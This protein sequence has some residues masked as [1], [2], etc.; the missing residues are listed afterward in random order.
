MPFFAEVAAPFEALGDF[1]RASR[2][3]WLETNG[4]GGYAMGTVAGVNTRRYHGHL[5]AAVRPPT[6]RALF[7]AKLDETALVGGAS[8]ELATNQYPGALSPDGWTRVRS[9]R[10][11]P[12]PTWRFD[13]GGVEVEKRLFLVHGEETCVVVYHASAPIV[14]RVL[15]FVAFRDHH[16]LGMAAGIAVAGASPVEVGAPGWPSLHLHHGGRF[17]AGAEVY[18]AFEHLEEM[19]RGFDFREDLMKVGAIELDV[20]PDRPGFVVATLGSVG[21]DMRR[22]A[23]AELAEQR[24]RRSRTEDPLRARLEA[25]AEHFVVSRADGSRTI[26]AGYPWF[27][28]WGR[29]TMISLPGLL[30]ARGRLDDARS[31]IAGFLAHLDRGL[32]PNRFPDDAGPPEY[33]TADATLWLFQA[34]HA[35]A[36]SGGDAGF[37]RDVV[38]PAARRIIDWHRRGTH[39]GIVVDPAD[40]LLVAG[41]PGTQ[42]TWMDA[43]VGGR[44][45]TPRHGKPVEV[46]ALWYNALRLA[47]GWGLAAGDAGARAY[48]DEAERVAASFAAAFW[49]PRRGC[50]F[51][52]VRDGGND[53]RVRPNQVLAVALPYPLLS[54]E[55]QRAVL[56]VVERD[57]LTDVGPR[58]LARGEPG[59]VGH[60][61][62]GSGERD[63]AYH[64]GAVWPWL[65]GPYVRAYLRVEERS[66]EALARARML[67]DGLAA[68]LEESG[69]LGSLGELFDGDPPHLPGG[70]PA[71]AWSVAEVLAL[72]AGEL[73][74]G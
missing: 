65:V 56:T 43:V 1:G 32:I 54:R 6:E 53:E 46:N 34:V 70:A 60:Y 36:S 11:A 58:T 35:Y 38:Y 10:L 8:I 17:V 22:V 51:D 25:A 74:P 18:R 55:Q 20:A 40:G 9:F 61:R 45:A 21:W 44:P 57:L 49:N 7:L 16:A 31:V 30:V 73:A 50:L 41:G 42:L 71:Q 69:C 14:L 72:I 23:A 24:R 29:D 33:N 62:G 68:R 39:G 4:T 64:Q 37:V 52:V 48:D 67:V 3:E 5:V 15:P 27:T 59:Y 19:E 13:A 12:Y 26:I 66:P 63:A 28:D 2:L 47:A